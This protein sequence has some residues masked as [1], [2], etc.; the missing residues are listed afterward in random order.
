LRAAPVVIAQLR[1]PPAETEATFEESPVTPTG[2][3][4]DTVE[5]VPS[6][7]VSFRPQ[8]FAALFGPVTAHVCRNPAEIE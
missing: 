8:H 3:V 4:V 5:P 1:L 6:S 2:V 7:P